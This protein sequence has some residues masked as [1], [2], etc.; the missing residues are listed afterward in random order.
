M[1]LILSPT[2]QLVSKMENAGPLA[3]ERWKFPP[4][5]EA[6][7]KKEKMRDSFAEWPDHL[8]PNSRRAQVY[9]ERAAKYF[10][11]SVCTGNVYFRRGSL[12]ALSTAIQRCVESSHMLDPVP[13]KGPS[14]AS[15]RRLL[16]LRSSS[17]GTSARKVDGK[18]QSLRGMIMSDYF[19]LPPSPK[20]P[21]SP[22]A[23]I[24]PLLQGA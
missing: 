23:T 6:A 1:M 3:V 19:Y 17:K 20:T 16:R 24:E 14:W 11:V 18:E 12:E 9:M 5:R 7:T 4:F 21:A 10:E 8:A 2:A 15:A 13:Q 22:W